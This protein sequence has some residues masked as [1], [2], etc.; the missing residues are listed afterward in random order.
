MPTLRCVVEA[1]STRSR[2]HWREDN[3]AGSVTSSECLRI[4][5]VT[6]FY[7]GSCCMGRSLRWT[8]KHS[9]DH[10][11]ATLKKSH[12]SPSDLEVLVADRDC[13]SS[14]CE[15]DLHTFS[16]DLAVAAD[17][18][19]QLRHLTAA[20]TSSGAHCVICGRVCASTFGLYAAANTTN[21]KSQP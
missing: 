19:R 18:R 17:A 1:M 3:H 15:S 7:I 6:A 12:T 9:S 10:A 20:S 11:K 5:F 13:W 14:T 21:R 16:C 8:K 2:S 4:E